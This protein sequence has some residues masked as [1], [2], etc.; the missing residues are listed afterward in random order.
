MFFVREKAFYKTVFSIAIP[1]ALQNVVG[2]VLNMADTVM[3]GMVDAK[4]EETI[5]AAG[6]ANQIYFLYSL[7]IFGMCSGSAVL[8]SQ[9]WGKKDF[10]SI[11]R[12][13]GISLMS[14]L[15][16]GLIFTVCC[17]TFAPN[18]ISVFTSSQEVINMGAGY[19]RI[20]IFSYLPATLTLILGGSLRATEQVKIVLFTNVSAVFINIVLN[21]VLI[22]GK[23]GAPV[24]GI[25]GAAY[26]TLI[27]R[28]VEC[29]IILIYVIFFEKRVNYRIR[30]MLKPGKVLI[31]DFLRYSSPVIFNETLWGLGITIH[32]VVYGNMGDEIF[33]AYTIA[34]VFE[35]IGILFAMGFSNAA[36]I[37]IGREIGAGR[38]KNVMR[39]ARVM[40][41]FSAASVFIVFSTIVLFREPL[42]GIYGN[43]DAA[44]AKTVSNLLLVMLLITTVKGYNTC[45]I[46]GTIRAGGDTVTGMFIDITPMYSIAIPLGFVFAFVLKAPIYLVYPVL[47]SDELLKVVINTLYI[48]SGRW[49]RR[50]TRDESN[51]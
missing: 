31:R 21:Y 10:V 49:I 5:A 33:A 9:Y 20:V 1:I 26:A 25:N 13:S 40:L 23:F 34:A 41:F 22:F 29:S 39:Y 43:I 51:L 17:F 15:S 27:A 32:S 18:I 14:A 47:M 44:T 16:L 8:I 30:L 12:V 46:V 24:L 6:Y 2:T 3:L 37:I 35:K 11:N 36:G 38:E 7:F 19:L 48:A 45:A 4:T 28:I 42:I 50:I